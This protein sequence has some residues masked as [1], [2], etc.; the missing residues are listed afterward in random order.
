[1]EFFLQEL[2]IERRGIEPDVAWGAEKSLRNATKI[3]LRD[4][5]GAKAVLLSIKFG[6]Y[7]SKRC[8]KASGR[9][10]KENIASRPWFISPRSIAW[11]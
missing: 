11:S 5:V 8:K 3:C 1:L 10:Q 4:I 7:S 9:Q 6:D 2:S